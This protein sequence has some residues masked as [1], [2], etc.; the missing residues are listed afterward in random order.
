MRALTLIAILF[1]SFPALSR[2]DQYA[3]G[4]QVVH[5][6]IAPVVVHRVLPPYKGIH[7]YAGRSG[8]R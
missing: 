6:R 7:V 1:I 4:S 3:S 2:A 8:R 5:T